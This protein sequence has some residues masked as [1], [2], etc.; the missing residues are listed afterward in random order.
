MTALPDQPTCLAYT[1]SARTL[2][3]QFIKNLPHLVSLT[4]TLTLSCSQ[5]QACHAVSLRETGPPGVWAPNPSCG[6][7]VDVPVAASQTQV[8]TVTRGNRVSKDCVEQR[9]PPSSHGHMNETQPTALLLCLEPLHS[10]PQLHLNKHSLFHFDCF[11]LP[12]PPPLRAQYFYPLH[13]LI[14]SWDQL[15]GFEWPQSLK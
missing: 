5:E 12:L 9:A 15:Y 14:I 7:H 11:F 1:I 13:W 2:Q 10:W 3:G 8:R 4:L 6:P